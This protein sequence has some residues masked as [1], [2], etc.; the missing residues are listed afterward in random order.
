MLYILG[1]IAGDIERA[2]AGGMLGEFMRPELGVGLVLRD[3]V[4]VGPGEEVFAAEFL[5]PD[6]DGLAFPR[7]DGGAGG[8]ACGGVGGGV[9]VVLSVEVAVLRIGAV[10]EVWPEAV[11]APGVG[12]EELVLGFAAGVD[13]WAWVRRNVGLGWWW[14][15]LSRSGWRG[16]W[17]GG[18]SSGCRSGEKASLGSLQRKATG[19]KAKRLML[20]SS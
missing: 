4:L 1:S 2:E 19:S 11:K 16:S 14:C 3:P 8:G 7:G 20:T 18:V 9:G 12:W 6:V 5:D 17:Q 15:L 13:L 10:A